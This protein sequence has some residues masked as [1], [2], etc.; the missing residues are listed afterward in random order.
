MA[1]AQV[2]GDVTGPSVEELMKE[3]STMRDTGVTAEELVLA[4]ESIT[5]PLPA[6]F[7]TSSVTARTMASL[8]LFDL[9]LDYYETLPSRI[10]GITS[11]DVATVA[12]KFLTPE[13]MV[14]VAVGDRKSIQPQLEK[15]NLGTVAIRNA[16]GA[17]VP[18]S[19]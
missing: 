7:E 6:N 3:V 12:K 10:N 2:R 1:G 14:V 13:R 17:V 11:A 8:Y 15:L 9:P 19:N 18:T 4:K 16:D 5:R